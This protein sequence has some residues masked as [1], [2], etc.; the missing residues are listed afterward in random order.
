MK[1]I[2]MF[3]FIT[4][5]SFGTLVV[6]FWF[7]S[8]FRKWNQNFLS[9]DKCWSFWSDCT[10]KCDLML[11]NENK[12]VAKMRNL[13]D[14]YNFVVC[15]KGH[16]RKV[17]TRPTNS[18]RVN[19]TRKKK[20]TPLNDAMTHLAQSKKFSTSAWNRKRIMQYIKHNFHL[21][22]HTNYSL[23]SGRFVSLRL[24]CLRSSDEVCESVC[25]PL[26]E[27][28]WINDINRPRPIPGCRPSGDEDDVV[29]LSGSTCLVCKILVER[30][31]KKPEKCQ[32]IATQRKLHTN[33]HQRKR[34]ICNKWQVKND[35]YRQSE[36][37]ASA[38]NHRSIITLLFAWSFVTT[39]IGFL[40]TWRCF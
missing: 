9:N 14:A 10:K 27:L 25:S 11:V 21:F 30:K 18:M 32:K 8:C 22:D 28:L 39:F 6:S 5:H 2:N 23:I 1:S 7:K 37:S 40:T 36:Q 29:S 31:K 16:Y 12:M 35:I 38:T 19:Q 13:K 33:L 26:I 34:K 3:R 20:K 17:N 15:Y 4:V 24:C